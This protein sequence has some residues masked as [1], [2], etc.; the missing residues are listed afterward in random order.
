MRKNAHEKIIFIDKYFI[1]FQLI[2]TF[3][4]FILSIFIRE[5]YNRNIER[6]SIFRLT[7]EFTFAYK[8]RLF[9]N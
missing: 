9:S 8:I 4:I 1:I 7:L 5:K 3:F 2:F 6:N